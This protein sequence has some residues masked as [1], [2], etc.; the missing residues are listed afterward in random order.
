MYELETLRGLACRPPVDVSGCNQIKRYYCQLHSIQSRFPLTSERQLLSFTWRDA[1]SSGVTQSTD[2]RFEMAAMLYNYGV[3]HTQLAAQ[4]SRTT[5]DGIKLVCTHFQCA[6]WAFAHIRDAFPQVNSGDMASD[7]LVFMENLCLAQ[8][9]ECILEKSLIDNRKP[10]I[11]AKVTAQIIAYYNQAYGSLLNISEDGSFAEILG[12][13]N[14]NF[15]D[16]KA[17]IQFKISYLSCILLLYRGQAAEEQQKMGERVTFYQASF[18][19]LEEAIKQAKG[20]KNQTQIAEMCSFVMDVVEA[21]RKAGKNENEFI[22]HEEVPAISNFAAVQGANLVKGIAFNVTDP[23]AAGEDIFKRLVPMKA[24]EASSVYSE[25]KADLLRGVGSRVQERDEECQ[26]FMASLNVDSL[27]ADTQSRRLPQGLIDRCAELNAKPNAIPDLVSAMSTLAETCTEVESMLSEIKTILTKE[28]QSEQSFQQQFGMGRPS[29]PFVEL[30]RECVK[31]QEAHSKAGESNDTLRKAMGLH[32]NNLKMLAKPL[33]EIQKLV[34]VSQEEIDPAMMTE[35][36]ALLAKV[37]EMQD[38]RNNL[39]NALRDAINLDDI[40]SQ[41]IAW[42]DKKLDTLFQQELKKHESAVAVIDKNMSAQPN[43]LRA[44]TECYARCAVFIKSTLDVKQKRD[45]FFTAL[46][47]SYDVYDDLLGKSSKGLEFYKK[48]QA[49]IQKL[50]ARVRAA[51]DVQ[52]EE[53]QQRLLSIKP[54]APKPV[55]TAA[56]PDGRPRLKDYLKNGL[57]NVNDLTSAHPLSVRPSPLGSETTTSVSCSTST[58]SD[59]SVYSAN[60][61]TYNDPPPPYVA[62]NQQFNAP[63]ASVYSNDQQMQYEPNQQHQHA[64]Q[65]PPAYNQYSSGM[66]NNDPAPAYSQPYANPTQMPIENNHRSQTPQQQQHQHQQIFAS[67]PTPNAQKQFQTSYTP[68]VYSASIATPQNHYPQ[69]SNVYDQSQATNKYTNA[70]TPT[71][72]NSTVSGYTYNPYT[73]QYEPAASAPQQHSV[74]NF[75]PQ[76]TPYL[77]PPTGQQTMWSDPHTP[78]SHRPSSALSSVSSDMSNLTIHQQPQTPSQ[79]Y[80]SNTPNSSQ[81]N[82]SSSYNTTTQSN[83]QITANVQ[84]ITGYDQTATLRQVYI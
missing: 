29:G 3:M 47:T 14:K 41:V 23:E 77:F 40:T 8:A 65:A 48:L 49:N 25:A 10:G 30:N 2:I 26:K 17:Q 75:Q 36:K 13:G 39:F 74:A 19:K 73:G 12:V 63:P 78:T 27:K 43:I 58:Y 61:Y 7:I 68:N 54:T 72:T 57:I 76:Q 46:A 83:Y 45:Q 31:Y 5:D 33:S 18:E 70:T 34:P 20:L 9:Q 59:S 32:L 21:K 50:L 67:P 69:Q 28:E 55:E 24:H 22:Y 80:T 1:F 38:Q 51:H 56:K 64:Y 62:Y 42:G 44:L 15:R 84:Y 6:A 81:T 60:T 52:D 53:R 82:S 35:L 37:K 4:D 66:A 16:Y 11:V 79:Q 71:E